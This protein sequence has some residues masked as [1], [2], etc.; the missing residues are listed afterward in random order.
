MRQERRAAVKRYALLGVAGYVAPKHLQAIRE[1]G[2]ELVAACDPHDS[3]GVLDRYFPRCRYFPE[4]ERFE[5]HLDRLR[6][7]GEA[8][9]FVSICTPSYLHDAH[10]RLALRNGAHA[11]CEKPLVLKPANL[12]ALEAVERETDRRVFPILQLRH[13]AALRDLRQRVLNGDQKLAVQLDYVTYRGPW[14]DQSWKGRAGQSGGLLTNIGVH[15]FDLLVWMFGAPAAGAP[16][17]VEG[18]ERTLRGRLKLP[19]ANVLWMLSLDHA[20]LPRASV[21]RGDTAWRRLTA[22]GLFSE[23]LEDFGDLHTEAYR[24]I[25]K[26]EG[27]RIDDVRPSLELVARLRRMAEERT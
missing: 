2:G 18:A 20:A 15:L 27:L 5:R 24:A 16:L 10:C 12:A 6:R 19:R 1:T 3:V 9:D 14:Y 7:D 23:Q 11:I 13:S 26:G 17:V 25:L 8:V 21:E 4:I 22:D